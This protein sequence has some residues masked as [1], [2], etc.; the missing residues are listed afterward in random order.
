MVRQLSS[1]P[2]YL[3][4]SAYEKRLEQEF[5]ERNL[6][7]GEGLFSLNRRRQPDGTILTQEE[8]YEQLIE[9]YRKKRKLTQKRNR[10]FNIR[11]NPAYLK[12][13]LD[14][15]KS[16]K[17]Q[18]KE[19]KKKLQ[20]LQE[21]KNKIERESGRSEEEISGK[22]IHDFSQIYNESSSSLA[23][24]KN[25]K[26]ELDKTINELIELDHD[27]IEL[28]SIESQMTS[29][30]FELIADKMDQEEN[31]IFDYLFD[32]IEA[33]FQHERDR[34][35]LRNVDNDNM[36][37]LHLAKM[38]NEDIKSEKMRESDP[39]WQGYYYSDQAKITPKYQIQ[40]TCT[41]CNTRNT[42]EFSKKAYHE[43]VVIVKCSGCKNNHIIADN[44]G[45]F[46]DLEG[47][48]NIEEILARKGEVVKKRSSEDQ[49]EI[50]VVGKTLSLK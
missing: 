28:D 29:D 11:N 31:Q 15:K 14:K 18:Q 7:K 6:N 21:I 27:L 39:N 24:H 13:I 2:L 49:L 10:Q 33:E 19:K 42:A 5:I 37:M 40:Y 20:K 4:K 44:L 23:G 3:Q 25:D 48:T 32:E 26:E 38:I 35:G 43:T 8:F 47:A 16:V 34:K 9:K 17:F 30:D 46:S 41:V 12:E 1:T 22:R 45:W 36:D 50:D